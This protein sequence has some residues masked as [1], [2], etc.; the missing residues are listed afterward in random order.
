MRRR[1][2]FLMAFMAIA[3]TAAAQ[4]RVIGF[5]RLQYDQT[6][7]ADP[8]FDANGSMAALLKVVT[9]EK[10][11]AFD[12]GKHGVVAVIEHEGEVW[13]Y[14]PPRAFQLTITHK[15]LGKASFSF[16][17]IIQEGFT[18]EMML[19]T[20][21]GYFADLLAEDGAEL[22]VDGKPVGKSPLYKRYLD[23]GVHELQAV[24]G[25]RKGFLR[26]PNITRN[27]NAGLRT[28]R[29]PMEGGNASQ[30]GTA[31]DDNRRQGVADQRPVT[32][33][34][35]N[36]NKATVTTPDNKPVVVSRDE[37]QPTVPVKKEQLSE[38]DASIPVGK[39]DPNTFAVIIGNEKYKNEAEVPF[40]E[41]DALIFKAYAE[42]TL[43]IPERQIK[44]V[45][46]AGLNDLRM[47]V[48][49]LTQ[50]MDACEGEARAIFYY[51]GHGIP[52]EA[53]KT[54]Y[55]L[56]VDGLGGDAESAYALSRL[57][58]ELGQMPAQR[59]MV[60]LDACFSGAKREG[61]MMAS[62]RGV[63]IKVKPSAP[64]GNMVVF[65]AAQDDQTAFPYKSE[66]H[67][68]FTYYL[69]SK[70]RET[71][72]DVTLGELG[73]YVTKN[74]KRQSLIENNKL[75]TPTVSPSSAMQE[76]WRQMP[77]R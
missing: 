46:N 22:F 59:V 37:A 50:V 49:W 63:A 62:A 53:E 47:A 14:L 68:M 29:V 57:Y 66:H 4:M 23:Y 36:D 2:M 20:G 71:K 43:G 41:H 19:D 13:V 52:D 34:A 55:L 18:Y 76:R 26:T 25:D 40:A 77:V 17:L 64:K 16:P 24:K 27:N 28:Y 12:G 1:M 44:L 15:D 56:P 48:R 45:T 31:A 6:A 38:I 70:L 39:A 75:Q 60:F 35:R 58:Q 21:K 30:G 7:T 65:T 9:P 11:L 54:A 5:K 74:V 42:K 8:K 67:G 69:L 3:I 10:G 61:G 72:G 32:P 73:D 33:I 51:A